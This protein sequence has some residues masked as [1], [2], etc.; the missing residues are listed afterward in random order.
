MLLVSI[1]LAFAYPHEPLVRR[2]MTVIFVVIF[3]LYIMYDTNQILRD[4]MDYI[5]GSFSYYLDIINI[6]QDL[7]SL[8][9]DDN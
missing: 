7:L 3:S 9:S 8:F 2:V 1:V 6:F 4:Q 5:G